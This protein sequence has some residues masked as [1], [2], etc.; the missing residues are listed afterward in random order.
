MTSALRCDL[1]RLLKNTTWNLPTQRINE[2]QSVRFMSDTALYSNSKW[3]D[4]SFSL[5]VAGQ[6]LKL[7]NL[8]G[9]CG[10]GERPRVIKQAL[11]VSLT[12]CLFSV[13]SNRPHM[14]MNDAFLKSKDWAIHKLSPN[15]NS[16]FCPLPVQTCQREWRTDSFHS[17]THTRFRPSSLMPSFHSL[18]SAT[19]FFFEVEN[20]GQLQIGHR[21]G[22]GL[23][24]FLFSLSNLT[25]G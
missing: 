9:K 14:A 23:L 22:E 1:S 18:S 24:S 10:D 15:L 8:Q 4:F 12:G 19:F 21:W 13:N 25:V 6:S 5:S 3:N 2:R 16:R 11:F 17:H 7:M 20:G